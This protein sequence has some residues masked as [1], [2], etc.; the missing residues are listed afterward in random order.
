[1]NGV[2]QMMVD[3]EIHKIRNE[4]ALLKVFFST[5]EELKGIRG[6]EK[7]IKQSIKQCMN[8]IVNIE[9]LLKRIEK[10]DR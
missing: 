4:L 8:N 7:L 3:K 6:E 9:R 10:R 1:M 2:W 5:Y